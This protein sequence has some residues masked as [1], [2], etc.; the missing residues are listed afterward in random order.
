MWD[1]P[2]PGI[3]PVSPALAGGLLTT[4]PPE[5][6]EFL[7]FC[8]IC[9][10]LFMVGFFPCVCFSFGLWGPFWL[11]F[12]CESPRRARTKVCITNIEEGC[13][14][15][16]TSQCW[17]SYNKQP[18]MHSCDC[19]KKYGKIPWVW[20]WGK[21]DSRQYIYTEL[22]AESEARCL[23]A[24]H[25]HKKREGCFGPGVGAV[26]FLPVWFVR[27]VLW[28][29]P[30]WRNGPKTPACQHRGSKFIHLSPDSG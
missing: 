30:W 14:W 1:L 26:V 19:L 7:L 22:S 13:D 10:V 16:N 18:L 20:Q 12:L 15:Q 11:S 17:A 6:S 4:G 27:T 2:G 3:E 8:S 9:S 24:S 25:Q 23:M 28:L 5:K 29:Q 21:D